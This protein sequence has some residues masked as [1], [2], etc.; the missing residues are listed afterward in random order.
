VGGDWRLRSD[1][2]LS[3]DAYLTNLRNQFVGTVTP[4]GTFTPP[5]STTAIP[6]FVSTNANLGKARFEGVQVTLSKDVPVGVGYLVSGALQRAYA[7]GLDPSFYATAFGPDTTNIGVVPGINYVG[8]N[9]PFFNG[10]SNK[11]EAYSQ[12]YAEVHERYAH[13]QYF[14]LGATF[15]GANNT[16]NVPAFLVMNGVYRLPVAAKTTLQISADNLLGAYAQPYLLYG[17]GIAAP[18]VNGQVGLRNV[19]PYGPTVLHVQLEH[20]F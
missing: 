4:N 8:D 3:V 11:S 2:V 6:V 19:V 12:G 14:S 17:T 5:G 13:G 18:L 7:Y 20:A 10:I 16:Y 15:Y 1:A 9:K